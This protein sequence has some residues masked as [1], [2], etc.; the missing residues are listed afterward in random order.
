MDA[1]GGHSMRWD[2]MGGH[3]MRWDAMKEVNTIGYLE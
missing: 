1:M 3:A 2:A